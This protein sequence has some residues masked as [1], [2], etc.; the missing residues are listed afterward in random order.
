MIHVYKRV[1]PTLMFQV[2]ID[3][4][5]SNVSTLLP[6]GQAKVPH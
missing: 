5:L 1:M 6:V 3:T 2:N 4:V